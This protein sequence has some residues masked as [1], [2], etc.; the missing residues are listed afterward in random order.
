MLCAIIKTKLNNMLPE[1]F[2]IKGLFGVFGV[3]SLLILGIFFILNGTLEIWSTIEDAAALKGWVILVAIPIVVVSYLFGII[4]IELADL[5]LLRKRDR[6]K[7]IETIQVLANANNEFLRSL[8]FESIQ[9]QRL[10]KGG[11]IAFVF[12]SIGSLINGLH[13]DSIGAL[14][15]IGSLGAFSLTFICIVI[16]RRVR[17]NFLAIITEFSSK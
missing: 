5:I 11:A 2:D 16:N 14:G 9:T 15:I 13:W 3:G 17:S 7:D 4:S 1:K 10:L 12:V 6:Q 8:Y